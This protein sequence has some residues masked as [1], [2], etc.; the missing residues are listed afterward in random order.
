MNITKIP[1]LATG[2]FSGLTKAYLSRNE[3]LKSF[4][5]H[6]F[7]TQNFEAIIDE[8]KKHKVNRVNLY[9]ALHQQH[10]AFYKDFSNLEATVN[11]IKE[12]TTFT[13][14]T[15][16]QIC[17]ASGPLY[18]IYKIAS[19][20]NLCQQLKEKYPQ[21]NFVP[22]Y[23][24]ATED[25]DFEEI[26]HIHLFNKKIT[27]NKDA[28]GATG[29]ISTEGIQYFLNEIKEIIGDK[30]V[31]N[32]AIEIILNCYQNYSNLAEATRAMVLKLFGDRGLLVLD[33]DNHLLKSE[34]KEII[35]KDILHQISY[36]EVSKSIHE[37]VVLN[38]IKEDKIQVKPRE[39]NFFYLKDNFRKRLVKLGKTY[40]VIDTDIVFSEL[41]LITE[42]DKFPERFSPN[43]IMRPIYQESILPN[44]VYI[45]GAG[46]LSYW[47]ELKAA[48]D[49]HQ[50]FFPS[51]ALRNSF[52]F[53][54][55]KQS[56]KL[57]HLGIEP[58]ELFETT[59]VLIEKV[60]KNTGVKEMSF[61]NE[62][63]LANSLFDG[64]KTKV[65]GIEATLGATADAERHKLI[66]SIELLEQKISKAQK[67]KYETLINQLKKIKE[68]LFPNGTLQERY[69]NIIWLQHKFGNQVIDELINHAHLESDSFTI[70]S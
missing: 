55:Q 65:M 16:H 40:S 14:T 25:H 50:C 56:E 54:D 9:T 34:F 19:A 44:L 63:E 11:S 69:D 13:I 59:E 37:L 70:L 10:A 30:S 32:E 5:N 38:L 18:F 3:V 20:I 22:L 17:L 43:V 28:V 29:R 45:G 27:W 62:I 46:E 1:L 58:K 64:L 21:Y 42:I 41:E 47:F 35:K 15:G 23:W 7:N 6:H 66:K 60:L 53:I 68:S 51:L 61:A 2:Y 4:Y 33:A 67:L 36:Q 26:N 8:R 12:D 49:K 57:S 52:L 48:F 31:N 39:I 24:M